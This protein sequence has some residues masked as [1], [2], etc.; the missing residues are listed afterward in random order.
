M[1]V[2]SHSP[3]ALVI[4]SQ[5]AL[6]V[7]KSL[8]S[9]KDKSISL[10]LLIVS[11]YLSKSTFKLSNSPPNSNFPLETCASKISK[12]IFYNFQLQN[13]YDNIIKIGR[14]LIMSRIV[15]KC[16]KCN[17][18]G[19]CDSDSDL[20]HKANNCNGK[21]I[22]CHISCDDLN[23]I[24]RIAN[25]NDLFQAMINLKETDPIEYQLKINQFK[26]Q[27]QQQENV[28]KQQIEQSK[29]HCPYCNSVNVKKISSTERVAS[30]AMMGIFSKKINKSFKCSNC[31]GTF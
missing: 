25:D 24:S 5:F 19:I 23:I 26:T 8:Y 14:L 13:I 2:S 9:G 31:G 18:I 11:L 29:V 15:V 22:Q 21:L 7:L 3:I 28:Q 30:V 20:I 16:D 4:A 6:P 10:K 12:N 1:A 17:G 27:V